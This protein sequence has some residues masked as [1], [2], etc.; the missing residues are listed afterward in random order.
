MMAAGAIR[1]LTEAGVSKPARRVSG[2]G[3]NQLLRAVSGGII[4][5]HFGY[6]TLGVTTARM[7]LDLIQQDPSEY[8]APRQVQVGHTIVE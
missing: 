2:F 5:V 8:G 4:T 1:A 3:D 7:A 6:M